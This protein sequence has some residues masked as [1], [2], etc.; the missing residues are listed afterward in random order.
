MEKKIQV[1]KFLLEIL[2][3]LKDVSN[4][5]LYYEF[6]TERFQQCHSEKKIPPVCEN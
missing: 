3:S 2:F 4:A 6:R 1:D 5:Q